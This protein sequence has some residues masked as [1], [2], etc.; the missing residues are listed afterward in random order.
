MSRDTAVE[1]MQKIRAMFNVPAS[2]DDSRVAEHIARHDVASDN[3]RQAAGIRPHIPHAEAVSRIE[4]YRKR[5]DHLADVF[6]AADIRGCEDY[7]IT[8]DSFRKMRG[9]AYKSEVLTGRLNESR[10]QVA[11]QKHGLDCIGIAAGMPDGATIEELR[12]RVLDMRLNGAPSRAKVDLD[13][14]RNMLDVPPSSVPDVALGGHIMGR[15]AAADKDATDASRR[16]WELRAAADVSLLT[17]H[18]EAVQ[19]VAKVQAASKAFSEV[20]RGTGTDTSAMTVQV[21]TAHIIDLMHQPHYHALLKD[22]REKLGVPH[23]IAHVDV[24]RFLKLRQR[25]HASLIAAWGIL[26]AKLNV[27]INVGDADVAGHLLARLQY[28][29]MRAQVQI[30]KTEKIREGLGAIRSFEAACSPITPDSDLLH[31]ART[32]ATMLNASEGARWS[33]VETVA[34]QTLMQAAEDRGTLEGMDK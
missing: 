9:L 5:A 31:F 13:R 34:I 29:D 7:A 2:T 19:E 18:V 1:G 23:G 8:L 16:V 20:I 17:P 25:E 3:L 28:A 4:R 21:A 10:A 22:V 12:V 11:R 15:L 33:H 24:A 6:D 14:V 26:R 30:D 27:P 32:V